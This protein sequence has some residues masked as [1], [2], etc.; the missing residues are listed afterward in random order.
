VIGKIF[1]QIAEKNARAGSRLAWIARL[2]GIF[3]GLVEIAAPN[4][5]LNL[6]LRHWLKLLYFFEALMIIGG[7]LLGNSGVQ[8]FGLLALLVTMAINLTTLY[9]HDSMRGRNAWKKTL[10]AILIIGGVIFAL[11]GTLF[12]ISFFFIDGFWEIISRFRDYFAHLPRRYKFLPGLV[13]GLVILLMLA[14]Q[15][16]REYKAESKWR[17]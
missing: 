15:A 17:A 1:E 8:Q 12:F 7:I 5:L 6:L 4:S 9:L 16:V 10:F 2:G 3:W 14:V 11:L 13:L